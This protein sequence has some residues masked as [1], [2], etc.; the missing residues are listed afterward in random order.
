MRLTMDAFKVAAWLMLR[1]LLRSRG[2]SE[3]WLAARLGDEQPAFDTWLLSP[4]AH[5]VGEYCELILEA[6]GTPPQARTESFDAGYVGIFR[7]EYSDVLERPDVSV[8]EVGAL[9]ADHPVVMLL[10]LAFQ[11]LLEDVRRD[12]RIAEPVILTLRKYLEVLSGY[13]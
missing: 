4:E 12:R 9:A 3:E 10:D 11:G 2:L 13:K 7:E 8:R 1:D 5:R 6:E